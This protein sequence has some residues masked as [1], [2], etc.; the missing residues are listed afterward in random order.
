MKFI[1]NLFVNPS[2]AIQT[3]KLKRRNYFWYFAVFTLAGMFAYVKAKYAPGFETGQFSLIIVY[4]LVG[5]ISTIIILSI[6]GKV[7]AFKTISFND[8]LNTLLPFS[9]IYNVFNGLASLVLS[10]NIILGCLLSGAAELW[11]GIVFYSILKV[12]GNL[13]KRRAGIISISTMIVQYSC[14]IIC[15]LIL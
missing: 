5:I 10:N 15:A 3:G 1:I 13:R 7:F 8:T 6:I 4:R 11:L 14:F 12:E 9:V 2:K